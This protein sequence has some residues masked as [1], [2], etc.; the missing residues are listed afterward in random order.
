MSTNTAINEIRSS[1]FFS[2]GLAVTDPAVTPHL[3]Q[4]SHVEP[5]TLGYVAGAAGALLVFVV[6]FVLKKRSASAQAD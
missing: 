4:W 3:V 2:E 6:G 1:G 5:S